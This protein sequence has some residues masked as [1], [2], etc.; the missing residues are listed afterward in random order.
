VPDSLLLALQAQRAA[1]IMTVASAGNSGSSCS[2]VSDPPSYHAEVYTVGALGTG[3]DTIADFSSRGPATADGSGRRKPDITAPGT[4]TRSAIPTNAYTS[5]SGTSM[6]S[7]HVAGAV[8]LLWSARPELKNNL[9]LT[10]QLLDEAAAHISDSTCDPA[11]TTWPNNTYG[12][13]RLDIYAAMF[14]AAVMPAAST[15]SADP[16]T[17]VTYTLRVTNTAVI[18]DS[19]A[20]VVGSPD[21]AVHIVP[22]SSGSLQPGAGLDVTVTLDVPDDALAYPTHVVTLTFA[23]HTVATRSTA[24]LL[25]TEVRPYYAFELAAPLQTQTALPGQIVSY[26]IGL[27]NTGNIT[28]VL[29]VSSRGNTWLSAVVPT[30]VTL[31]PRTVTTLT[32]FV[33]SPLSATLGESD[34]LRVTVT[35]AASSVSVDLITIGQVF[36]HYLPMLLR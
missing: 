16:G 20:F 8:A 36:K 17:T 26:S 4:G 22:A 12:Y 30:Q 34:T 10:E 19:L 28:D 32:A 24:A 1:G 23:S 6:A 13:G 35:G 33:L 25:M 2:T 29:S 5:L 27:T 15:Q 3:T 9:D 31:G 18:T 7:P 14:G 11:G 21:W